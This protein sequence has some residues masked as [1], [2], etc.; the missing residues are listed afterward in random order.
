MKHIGTHKMIRCQIFLTVVNHR[1]TK[2]RIQ[3]DKT[4]IV[5]YLVNV[6]K[7][8][9]IAVYIKYLNSSFKLN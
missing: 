3:G 8:T 1:N 7:E 6:P 4:N 9:V 5:G 2:Y